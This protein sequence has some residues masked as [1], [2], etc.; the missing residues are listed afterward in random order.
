MSPIPSK[1]VAQFKHR[2]TSSLLV[3]LSLLLVASLACSLP[4]A[5]QGTPTP[6]PA[7]VEAS[8]EPT[9]EVSV[10][11]GPA[12][13]LPPALV[14]TYPPPGAEL[15]LIGP[16]TLYFNQPMDTASVEGA[17]SGQPNLSGRFN[18]QGDSTVSFTP[19]SPFMPATR[20]AISLSPTARSQ[21]GL[22]LLNPLT[23]TYRTVGY[24]ELSQTLPEPGS[25]D[26]NPTSAVVASFNR[27]VV[28]LGS[29]STTDRS[30]GPAA[31]TI[32]APDDPEPSGFGEWVN[33]STYIFYPAP[34]L[35]GGMVYT[36]SLNPDLVGVDGSPLSVDEG[37][38]LPEAGSW[39]FTTAVPRLVSIDPSPFS[40]QIRLDYPVT[41]TFNQPMDSDSVTS[42][43]SML[44]PDGN[45]VDGEVEW[46]EDFTEFTFTPAELYPRFARFT[47]VLTASTQARGGTQLGE[48][49]QSSFTTSPEFGVLETEPTQGGV[50]PV[51][52]GVALHFTSQLPDEDSIEYITISPRVSD[53]GSYRIDDRSL[54]LYGNFSPDTSY[55][56]TISDQLAD[57][58]GGRM[59]EPYTLEFSTSPLDPDLQVTLGTDVLFITSQENSL[60]AQATNISSL[61]VAVGSVPLEDFLLM[62]GPNSWDIRQ[63]YQPRQQRTLTQTVSLPPNRSEVV[64][65]FLTPD[66]D[67]LEPGLYYLKMDIGRAN[68][69]GGPFLLVASDIHLTFKISNN[70]VLVWA[71][72]LKDQSPVAGAP[73]TV[74]DE[75]GIEIA[76]G[77]TDQEGIFH[78]VIDPLTSSYQSSYAVLGQPGSEN[79]S[80]ALSSWSFGINPWEYGLLLDYNP[81]NQKTYLYTDRPIYQ[82]GDT[83]FF[84]LVSRQRQGGRYTLPSAPPEMLRIYD[85]MS[86]ELAAFEL[87]LSAYGT[88]HG[89]Y[90][91]LP[92]AQPGYYRLGDGYEAVWFQVADYRKPEINLQV[93]FEEDEILAGESISALVEARYF[94]DAPA[95]NQEIHWAVYA[96]PQVYSLP[97]YA[98]GSVSTSWFNPYMRM[99]MFGLDP[100]GYLVS[101]GDAVLGRDGTLVLDVPVGS[102]EFISSTDRYRLTLEVTLKDESGLPVSARA[103]TRVNPAD[104]IIGI[105]PDAWTARAEQ[106]AGFD[107]YVADWY[108]EPAGTKSLRAEFQKVTWVRE[109]A[110]N[111]YVA[112][113]YIPQYEQVGSADF[114]TGNDGLA[115][116]AFTPPEPGTYQLDVY[117]D[118][119]RSEI[120]LWVGGPGTAIWPNLP[121]QRMRLTASQPSYSPGEMA[122][123]FIP[124][125]MGSDTLALVTLEREEVLHYELITIEAA[126]VDYTFPVENRYIPNIYLSVTFLGEGDQ[127]KPDFRQGFLNLAV[128]PAEQVLNI[129]LLDIGRGTSLAEIPALGPGEELT[130]GIRVTDHGGQ[131]VEGEFSLSVVDLAVLALAEPNAPDITSALY[132]ER[133]LGVKTGLSL[134]AYTH[135]SGLIHDGVGGGGGEG[136]QPSVVRERFP[137]TAYWNATVT[138]NANGEAQVNLTLPDTLTTWRVQARGLNTVT[139]V[140]EA[141]ADIVATKQ[142]LIRPVAPRFLVRDDH[143]QLS[144]IVHNN[145]GTELEVEVSL[146]AAGVQLDDPAQSIHVV[147]V[148][149]GS[150]VRLDWW[151]TVM[152]AETA[153]LVFSAVAGS[154]QDAA[155]P[156]GGS[157]PILR[158]SAPQTFATS[159]ILE[160]DGERLELVSLPRTFE[161]TGGK[162]DV[163]L[164]PS[165]GAAI[166]NGLSAL[167]RFPYET[168][169]QTISRF[170]PN[171][172]TYRALQTFGVEALELQTR[173]ER[174]LDQGLTRLIARQNEDGGWGWN[175]KGKSDV[176]VSTYILFGLMRARQ[177]GVSVDQAV[178]QRAVDYLRAQLP[179]PEISTPGWQ[180]D[181]MAFGHYVLTL[182]GSGDLSAVG[183]VYEMHD[184]LN[185]WAQAF[186]ALT[187]EQLS[188]TDDRAKAL[189]SDLQTSAIRSATGAHWE[190]IS[191][192]FENFSSPIYN[193][194]VVL[195]ALAQ[196]VPAAEILPDALRYLM[197]HRQPGGCWSNSYD[198][199]WSLMAAIEVMKGT[200]ELGAGYAFSAILNG[201]LIA[202]G[203]A[204]GSGTEVNTV[205][206]SAP[207]SS[208]YPRDPNALNI[209]REP[210]TGRLYYTASLQVDRPVESAVPL[211]QGLEISRAY[212][213]HSRDCPQRN[214]EPV[215]ESEMGEM[216]TARVTLVLPNDAYYLMVE[217]YL[218]AGAEVRD[219]SLKTSQL[220]EDIELEWETELE[221]EP[222]YDYRRP[223]E[224]GWG[225]WLFQGPQIYADHIAW[226]ADYLPAG[227]Y[228][229]TY[230]L[231][232]TQPG[233]FR[234]LPA[235]AWEFYFPE[236]QGTSAG[237]VFEISSRR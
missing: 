48:D 194:A 175:G 8:S 192:D 49:F 227:T 87:P 74:Y 63:T 212:Y 167:D 226:S 5:L 121:N 51:F 230:D 132:G 15:P 234:V 177:N 39:S 207:L 152:D 146:Q 122:S 22:A 35:A 105:R 16:I 11:K 126:G 161:P 58:W 66:G 208:L 231:V 206:A 64:E 37:Q 4:G 179:A 140:G 90:T 12:E 101:Q 189:L 162:L 165:L 220:G 3:V 172:E 210:G 47:A 108:G 92:E 68:Y 171:L 116:V 160:S 67:P 181:R 55:S 106:E 109:D 233:E 99:F 163:E 127:G 32:S 144:G 104:F 96:A 205:T 131:P 217:D 147:N 185:P 56:L 200:G 223:F 82:P 85:E 123:V 88:A 77:I 76:R 235:R 201:T 42:N 191:Q 25:T 216:V 183:E 136:M 29:A 204:G 169:E 156:A 182:A 155:R 41:L 26:V 94:F 17:L 211:N 170:L 176:Y 81:S 193:S 13:P 149:S 218:P 138:T 154:L 54:G 84:R 89:E 219:V 40:T 199:A 31:F 18:W 21:N 221:P 79:F 27:P 24:L 128:D 203:Q 46:N 53:F 229:L 202:T 178:T 14:E 225:W 142:L 65:V 75:F 44:G 209:R 110:D 188:P 213:P 61:Q 9:S 117:G 60:L 59:D 10:P 45:P 80:F 113:E 93:S 222:L 70:D 107:V 214:C 100:L 86:Q 33:T 95:S 111:P 115:R 30:Q 43:F 7:D 224:D 134:A 145:T 151:G 62:L 157:I 120:L 78:S 71:I 72:D 28:S 69:Y 141:T 112:P 173:L 102:G 52:N 228:T 23:L 118:E 153:N 190:M 195:Y 97:G 237:T 164:S 197:H 1:V 38:G 187:I 73:V 174:N 168:N 198:T 129:E 2:N 133:P 232:V 236:V 83:V 184:Q 166:L 148:A 114:R 215:Q 196:R 158:Y 137:D 6:P 19:D 36:V 98:V 91:L 119:A 57:A 20:L 135:R 34:A 186:L 124:N 139:Q 150:Q 103:S 143:V 159:G 50:N 180:L 125:E 130:L